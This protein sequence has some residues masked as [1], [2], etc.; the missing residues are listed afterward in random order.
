MGSL[1]LAAGEAGQR[2]IL[3]NARVMIHQPRYAIRS[4]FIFEEFYSTPPHPGSGGASGQ[5]SDIA[6]H[7][8]EI[9]D[10]RK[11]LNQIYVHH[12]GQELSVIEAKMERDHFMSAQAAKEFGLVDKILVKRETTSTGE[13]K[14]AKE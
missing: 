3:P 5:A 10:I 1:L 2:S 9:L 4:F 8:Q 12:T 11:R 14:D 13:A 7:A 6:I